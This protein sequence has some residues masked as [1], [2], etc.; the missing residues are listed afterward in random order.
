M[1]EGKFTLNGS[2]YGVDLEFLLP[3]TNLVVVNLDI[4]LPIDNRAFNFFFFF[5]FFLF[6]LLTI[7][8]T[9]KVLPIVHELVH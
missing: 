3:Q 2:H 6:P 9:G 8:L 7:S 1:W 4:F 5:S